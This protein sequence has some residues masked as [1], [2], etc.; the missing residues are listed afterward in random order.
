MSRLRA[1]GRK[2]TSRPARVNL[3]DAEAPFNKIS[4]CESTTANL[5]ARS[6]PIVQ[7]GAPDTRNDK[8]LVRL[9]SRS[10]TSSRKPFA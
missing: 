1:S 9:G 4:A 10:S 3:P 5:L 7:L 2:P 6:S 8:K